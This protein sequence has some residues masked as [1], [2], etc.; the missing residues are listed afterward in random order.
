MLLRFTTSQRSATSACEP[1]GYGTTAIWQVMGNSG[2]HN[3]VTLFVDTTGY[4]HNTSTTTA[5][6]SS[7]L[8]GGTVLD[9]W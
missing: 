9:G 6:Y 8:G 3:I 1:L 5:L 7:C 2:V 4:G